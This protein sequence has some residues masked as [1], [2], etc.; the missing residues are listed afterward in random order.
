VIEHLDAPRL[1]AMERV[2]FEHARPRRVVI[3]TPNREYNVLWEG[4]GATKLRHHDHRFEWSRAECQA[5]A[6]RVAAS[7]GY[8]ARHVELGPVDAACGAPS[9]MV[10]FDRL[11]SGPGDKASEPRTEHA[12]A[13]PAEGLADSEALTT[14]GERTELAQ[15]TLD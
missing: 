14:D 15:R 11:G 6:E 9:Q 13:T 12:G 8:A 1:T 2:V 5:W 10:V 7:F 3:T 4:L